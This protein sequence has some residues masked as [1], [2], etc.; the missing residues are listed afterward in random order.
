VTKLFYAPVDPAHIKREKAKA[1]ELRNSPWWKQKLAQ[2]ICHYC[3]KKFSKDL[4]T[5]DHIVPIGRGGT[6]TKGNIVVCCKECNSKKQSQ[7][8]AELAL[9]SIKNR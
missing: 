2:G 8:A 9:E 7:T 1:K 6:S 3:E 4:L 5:M